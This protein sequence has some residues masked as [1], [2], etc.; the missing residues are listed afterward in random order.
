MHSTVVLGI[1]V[2]AIF[3]AGTTLIVAVAGLTGERQRVG[4]SL[5]AIRTLR[6]TAEARPA[7][8]SQPFSERVIDPV[9]RWFGA[10]GHRLT[11]SDQPELIRRR[12]DLA[13]NPVGW[14]VERVIA[15]KVLGL[16]LGLV[17]GTGVSVGLNLPLVIDILSTVTLTLLGFYA[18]DIAL[19]R[20]AALRNRRMQRDLP[21]A[22]DMLTI[23]VEAGLAFDAA[24]AQVARNTRG[25]LAAE[26]VRV[27]QEMQ[28]GLGRMEALR[29]LGERTDLPELRSFITAMIQAD[30][31]G[32]PIAG[33]LRVQSR[34]QR[35]RRSQRAEETAQRVPVMILFPLIFCILPTLFIVV[36]GPAAIQIYRSFTS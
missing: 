12:L 17:V 4:R 13:G 16:V 2:L 22:L 20:A 33:V 26:F 24:L 19:R 5:A 30:T 27:L 3:A 34:E 9:F 1:G 18:A 7:P 15:F 29:G 28:I 21:D 32:V 11:P 23:S 35:H 25:P 36:L 14:D 8:E 31:F 10:L 6:V